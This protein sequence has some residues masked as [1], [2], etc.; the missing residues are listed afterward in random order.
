MEKGKIAEEQARERR[1]NLLDKRKNT[2]VECV[3]L[4]IKKIYTQ[5]FETDF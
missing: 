4:R 2:V 5:L 3:I 1:T